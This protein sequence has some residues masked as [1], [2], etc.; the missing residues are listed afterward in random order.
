MCLG[1][2]G[3]VVEIID[4]YNAKTEITGVFRNVN[5]SYLADDQLKD[6]IG[7]WVLI[8]VGFAMSVINEADALASL[9]LLSEL[10]SD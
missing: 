1:V 8:H 10:G 5:T 9:K 2:P 4:E 6:L 7:K 3:K